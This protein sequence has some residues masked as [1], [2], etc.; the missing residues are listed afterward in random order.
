MLNIADMRTVHSREALLHA[1]RALRREGVRHGGPPVDRL[2]RVGRARDVR[3]SITDPISET[4][5]CRSRMSCS[6][7]S[8]L[9][10]P[11]S[12]LRP[13]CRRRRGA[14]GPVER[15]T[16]TLPHHASPWPWPRSRRSPRRCRRT[17]AGTR[18]GSPA[19]R[20]PAGSSRCSSAGPTPMTPAP[21]AGQRP[22][23]WLTARVVEPVLL[24]TAPGGARIARLGTAPSSARR[25]CSRWCGRRAGLARRDDAADRQRHAWAGSARARS[26]SG[27]V[28]ESVVDQPLA[29]TR[30]CFARASASCARSTVGV[31]RSSSPTPL[32]RFAV[33][34]RLRITGST[35]Y[36]C[37]A[38]A[39]SGP[40]AQRPRGLGGRRPP[41]HPR[42][43]G[44]ERPSAP[45]PR[46]AAC[47]PSARD[48]RRLVRDVPLGA[49][50]FVRA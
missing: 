44:P 22:R 18:A 29:A 25:A 24:R 12:A 50:V 5:T 9:T 13:S 42:H 47:T 8:A 40:P 17:A 39:L 32:G 1:A 49:P 26:V 30:C 10:R 11:A 41:R 7:A 48:M 28:T 43:A 46:W 4:T 15:Q 16:R 45:R 23:G 31:G 19:P 21:A 6:L 14:R 36:G 27:R 20:R 3:S 33:T 37:C 35:P 2:R 38:L 34:D